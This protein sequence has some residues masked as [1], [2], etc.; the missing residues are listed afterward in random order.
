MGSDEAMAGR[1]IKRRTSENVSCDGLSMTGYLCEE[2]AMTSEE[3]RCV[4]TRRRLLEIAGGVTGMLM[5]GWLEPW[6]VN[7]RNAH[8]V[9]VKEHPNGLI[10]TNRAW[11]SGCQRCELA[12]SIK[13]D[14]YASQYSARL[15][16]WRNYNFGA[17]VGSG[18]GVFENIQWTVDTCKQCADPACVASCPTGAMARNAETGL[19]SANEEAC[20]GCGACVEGCPWHMPR[21]KRDTS[22]SVKCVACGRCAEQCPNGAIVLVSWEDIALQAFGEGACN[23][24]DLVG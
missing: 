11:C 14:G 18:D 7:A 3:G 22:T 10:V 16:V 12:C 24:M 23:T 17:E 2:R 8:A 6:G 20:V 21:V 4:V 19:V 15:H 13:N 5:L 9:E 1:P